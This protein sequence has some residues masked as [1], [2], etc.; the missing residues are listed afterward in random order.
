MFA[1]SDPAEL[2]EQPAEAGSGAVLANS[3]TVTMTLGTDAAEASE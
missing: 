3:V 2:A 1:Q